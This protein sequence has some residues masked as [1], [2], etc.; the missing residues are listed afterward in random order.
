MP[1]AYIEKLAKE[2]HGT[3]AELEKKWDEAKAQAAK[4]G[5]SDN[6]A[7]VTSIFKNLSHIKGNAMNINA[8][9]RLKAYAPQGPITPRQTSELMAG[10]NAYLDKLVDSGKFTREEV[11]TAWA[12]A[13]KIANKNAKENPNIVESYAYT[14]AIFQDLLG[15]RSTASVQVNATYRIKA[16]GAGGRADLDMAVKYFYDI[17]GLKA[18]DPGKPIKPHI[19]RKGEIAFTFPTFP[20]A[21]IPKI[22][23][24]ITDKLG[25]PTYKGSD[26]KGIYRSWST[27]HGTV[28]F[29]FGF[30]GQSFNSL[31]TFTDTKGVK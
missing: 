21:V 15:I 2:G 29:Y 4:S 22:I 3:V 6:F 16:A 10:D 31:V 28:D 7:Y 13:K 8:S 25:N 26:R 12:Q 23:A 17:T 14:T 24:H 30:Q 9:H 5:Q 11:D 1:T 27:E 18:R 20:K 19:N